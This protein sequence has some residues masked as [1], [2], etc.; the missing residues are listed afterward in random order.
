MHISVSVLQNGQ[1]IEL[2]S[3]DGS[4][5]VHLL[6]AGIT[7]AAAWGFQEDQSL[8]LAKKY[9]VNEDIHSDLRRLESYPSLPASCVESSRLLL[10]KRNLY[11]RE[12]IFPQSVIDFIAKLLL[13]ENDEMMAQKLA[14][15]P[16]NDRLHEIRKIMHRNLHRH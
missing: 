14:D 13:A 15:L 10:E 6:L 3:P 4:A 12:A 2:R 9:Y 5:L 7:M 16:L 1:T 8:E 11:E